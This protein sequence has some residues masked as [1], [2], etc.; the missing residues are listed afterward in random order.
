MGAILLVLAARARR[1]WRSW[2]L[3]GQVAAI[4]TGLV[5]RRLPAPEGGRR[6]QA[7]RASLSSRL[8]RE[9]QLLLRRSP[10]VL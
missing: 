9:S 1:Y 4:G 10:G 8:Y 3:L 7:R 5:L 6:W 2:P